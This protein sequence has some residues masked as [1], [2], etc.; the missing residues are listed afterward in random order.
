MISNTTVIINFA[1]IGRLELLRQLF[2][3][4]YLPT[5]VYAEIRNARTR[6]TPISTASRGPSRRWAA[7]V[8]G[9]SRA[10]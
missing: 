5:E 3:V 10:L 2:S 6:G 4:L 8:R 7:I 9:E 1:A